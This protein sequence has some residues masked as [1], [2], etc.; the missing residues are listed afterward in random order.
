MSNDKN[1]HLWLPDIFEFKGGIQVYSAFLLEA[2]QKLY[3][4][5]DYHVFLKHDTCS[6]SRLAFLEHTNFHFTGKFPLPLRTGAYASQLLAYGLQQRPQLVISTHVNFAVAAY[7]LKRLAGIPYWAVAHGLEAWDIERPALKKALKGADRIIAVSGYTRDRLLGEQYLAPEQI[8]VLP[9][10]FD[11]NSFQIAPKPHNLL[12]RYRL[13]ESQPVIL[14]VGRLAMSDRYKGYD[15]ILRALPQI[16]AQI[17]NI[18]YLLVGEGSDRLRVE[19]LIKKLNLSDCVTLTGFV[20]DDELN[21]HYNLC[22]LFAMPSKGEGFGIVYLEA[23]ACG[24][25]TL[26]G[27]QDGAIDALCHGKLG[28]LVNPDDVD[29]IA[30]TIVAILQ[31]K[32][33]NPLLYQPEKLRQEVIDT[34]GFGQFQRT[35]AALINQPVVVTNESPTRYPQFG[36][37]KRGANSN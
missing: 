6:C 37:R 13:K 29:H 2:W 22:D 34:F 1:F 7:W 24:K 20:R 27:N 15:Q 14:T 21:A 9:N 26:G 8:S 17:P 4:Q 33:P 3:P 25:A 11:A 31:G 10:T 19:K 5:A 32:Y 16:R 23:L 35:L 30:H 12:Q 28:A 18:H 36:K